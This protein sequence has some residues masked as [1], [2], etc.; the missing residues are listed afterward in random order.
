MSDY[1]GIVRSDLRLERALRRQTL[2]YEEVEDF[3][4][5]TKVS[6]PLIELRNLISIA[7]LIITAAMNRK[8]SLGLHYNLDFEDYSKNY[9]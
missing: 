9:D 3:Y 6:I 2:L 7:Y 8:E 4:M 1:V 5:R